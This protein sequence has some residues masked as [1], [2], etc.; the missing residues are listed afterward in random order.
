MRKE[1]E[2]DFGLRTE[3]D[4]TSSATYTYTCKS[5]N[6]A[7][8]STDAI[9]VCFRTTNATGSKSFANGIDNFNR[10]EKLITVAA[11]LTASYAS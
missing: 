8:L 10:P 6:P 4:N 5:L 3:I 11:A 1:N 2:F 7:G 9:W